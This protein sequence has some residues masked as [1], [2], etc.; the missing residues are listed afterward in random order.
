MDTLLILIKICSRP[1]KELPFLNKCPRPEA[2]TL[3]S[4]RKCSCAEART[5]FFIK[6]YPWAE[7]R[8]HFFIR[9]CPCAEA[10]IL[11]FIR[12]CSCAEARAHFFIRMRSSAEASDLFF[13]MCLRLQNE[14]KY[15]VS[16]IMSIFKTNLTAFV[17]H[18]FMLFKKA[19]NINPK[20]RIILP[21]W[22]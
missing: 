6:K 1:E 5:H 12:K 10:W 14:H 19:L 2:K 18:I 16:H 3:F 22:L 20:N 7:A 13:R 15:S 9:K 8:T 21:L 4:I 17:N 11:F